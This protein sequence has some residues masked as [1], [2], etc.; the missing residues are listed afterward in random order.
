[1]LRSSRRRRAR[2]AAF[3]VANVLQ[4]LVSIAKKARRHATLLF[5]L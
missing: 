1:M 2:V 4:G 3:E 5:S